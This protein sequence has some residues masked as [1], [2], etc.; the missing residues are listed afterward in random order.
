MH[1]SP[2]CVSSLSVYHSS[3]LCVSF[4]PSLCIIPPLSV[5]HSSPFCFSSL[6][7]LCIIPSFLCIISPLSVYHSSPL[8]VS[9]LP[10][11]VSF[12][13][14]LCIIPPL[15]VYHPPL[16]HRCNSRLTSFGVAEGDRTKHSYILVYDRVTLRFF[17]TPADQQHHFDSF[18]NLCTT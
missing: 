1:P 7:S 13:P 15:S 6:P 2:L 5:Y 12:L 14:S 11:C 18:L 10:F 17:R 3:L 8:C 9:S 4:L 16:S